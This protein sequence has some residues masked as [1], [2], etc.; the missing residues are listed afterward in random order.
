VS[1]GFIHNWIQTWLGRSWNSEPMHPTQENHQ[2]HSYF[3]PDRAF[4]SQVWKTWLTLYTFDAILACYSAAFWYFF[5]FF[6]RKSLVVPHG[7]IV[8]TP[9]VK[10]RQSRKNYSAPSV[11]R[12]GTPDR[13]PARTSNFDID[14]FIHLSQGAVITSHHPLFGNIVRFNPSVEWDFKVI[15]YFIG[16]WTNYARVIPRQNAVGLTKSTPVFDAGNVVIQHSLAI[17]SVLRVYY[18][19]LMISSPWFNRN[20]TDLKV[21]WKRCNRL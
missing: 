7:T 11:I 19:V 12:C 8:L 6:S 16:D 10:F 1:D 14:K 17:P 5:L 15:G 21:F 20:V 3:H 4:N 9:G 13:C 18:L 2:P